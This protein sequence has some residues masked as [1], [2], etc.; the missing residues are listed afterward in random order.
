M[1]SLFYLV[2]DLVQ[3]SIVNVGVIGIV[4]ITKKEEVQNSEISTPW[5]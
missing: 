1:Q 2:G 5:K 4:S 3:I